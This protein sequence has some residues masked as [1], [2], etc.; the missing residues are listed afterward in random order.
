[1]IYC[2]RDLDSFV[3]IDDHW[4]FYTFVNRIIYSKV[5]IQH[6]TNYIFYDRFSLYTTLK[7]YGTVGCKRNVLLLIIFIHLIK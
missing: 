7:N 3:E 1:M 6:Y 2:L 5:G 4:F